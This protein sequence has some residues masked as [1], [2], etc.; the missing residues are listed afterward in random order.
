ML[1]SPLC[2]SHLFPRHPGC[3]LQFMKTKLDY[4]GEATLC[5]TSLRGCWKHRNGKELFLC[6]FIFKEHRVLDSRFRENRNWRPFLN[7]TSFCQRICFSF[8]ADRILSVRLIHASRPGQSLAQ[9]SE[10]LRNLAGPCCVP[11]PFLGQESRTPQPSSESR[12]R[13]ASP[14]TSA[15]SGERGL[16]ATGSGS[17]GRQDYGDRV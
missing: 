12:V 4:S 16:A 3:S 9:A 13:P 7:S 17:A 2:L 11:S 8:S 5:T 1:I 14:A 6:F 15:P 10:L